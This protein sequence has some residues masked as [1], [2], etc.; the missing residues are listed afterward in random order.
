MITSL[1]LICLLFFSGTVY[2][3]NTPEAKTINGRLGT[4]TAFINTKKLD[5]AEEVSKGNYNKALKFMDDKKYIE[6]INFFN[7]VITKDTDRYSDAQ[8]KIIECKN[9]YI[10]DSL[11]KSKIEDQNQNYSV[12]IDYLDLILKLDPTNSEAQKLK[13]AYPESIKKRHEEEKRIQEEVSKIQQVD[14]L[15]TEE[16]AI[17]IA[18]KY[19]KYKNGDDYEFYIESS[20]R[21]QL[22]D[23][24]YFKMTF[25]EGSNEEFGGPYMYDLYIEEKG[26]TLFEEFYWEAAFWGGKDR[27]EDFPI[28]LYQ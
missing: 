19:D 14:Q 3:Y 23:K 15:I 7:N 6:A 10:D 17:D 11:L 1:T 9:K 20:G 25:F 13:A 12:A 26:G 21:Q 8:S 2:S 27:T 4:T 22:G 18:I 24:S 28:K 5:N 16:Q